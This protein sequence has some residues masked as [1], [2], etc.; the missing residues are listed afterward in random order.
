V[1]RTPN[2]KVKVIGTRFRTTA[3]KGETRV[4]VEEGRVE[5]TRTSDG[6]SVAIAAGQYA[7]A[8]ANTELVALP[9]VASRAAQPIVLYRF[10]EGH[11]TTVHD[12]AGVGTPLNL[13]VRDATS[14]RWPPSGGLDLAEATLLSSDVPARNIL[15][16]C[17][18]TGE[19]TIEAWI[20]PALAK[21]KGP[22]RIVSL[23]ED[24]DQRNVTLGHGRDHDPIASDIYVVR[25]RTTETN[26]NGQ[27]SVETPGGTATAE[28]THVL[29]TRSAAGR[30]RVY[31][32]GI[33]RAEQKIGGDFS[34]WDPAYRL[35]LGNELIDERA[36]LGTY[37]LVAI[38]DRAL[39][40][41]EV[42]QNFTAGPPR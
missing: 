20:T 16:A 10:D 30:E 18:A 4:Q 38:Y 24:Y 3:M 33:C 21:Q 12:V 1:I 32:G 2:A 31:I 37:H 19:I 13:T 29:F 28:L 9:I 7:V 14:I 23:S 15:D 17:R 6:K 27:P 41:A 11:G 36:W 42:Q 39:T 25:L 35:L 40:E 8:A 22:A 26:D 34:G 5:L